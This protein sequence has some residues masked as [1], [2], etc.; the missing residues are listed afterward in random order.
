MQTIATPRSLVWARWEEIF[1]KGSGYGLAFVL[2]MAA[3]SAYDNVPNLWQKKDELAHVQAA[4]VPTL[5]KQVK[6]EHAAK[7]EAIHERDEAWA[8]RYSGEEIPLVRPR[9]RPQE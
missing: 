4:V 2:G 9:P 8:A 3:L 1:S 7:V 5:V 6:K